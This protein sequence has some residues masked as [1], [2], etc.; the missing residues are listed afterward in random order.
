MGDV[1][2]TQ[3]RDDGAFARLQEFLQAR[4]RHLLFSRAVVD[5][6]AELRSDFGGVKIFW[7]YEGEGELFLNEGFRTKEGDGEPLPSEYAPDAPEGEFLEVLDCLKGSLS[8]ICAPAQAAVYAIL[9]RRK[10]NGAGPAFVGD[11]AG[12]VWK[13]EHAPRPW[14]PDQRV[15]DAISYLFSTYRQRGYS[16]KRKGS[17]EKIMIGDQMITVAD[18]VMKVRGKFECLTVENMGLK[19]RCVPPVMRLRYLKDSS[20]GSNF[21]FDAFRRLP[22]TWYVN[23]PGE[24][25]D[26]VNFVNS[27]IVNIPKETSPSHFHPERPVNGGM[28]QDEM[29][30]V[31]DPKAYRLNTYGREAS[32][33]IYPDLRD[34]FRFERHKLEPGDIVYIPAG[35]GHRGM[36][37][38]VNVITIPG[39]KPHNEYYLDKDLSGAGTDPAV[40]NGSL[41]HLKNYGD[42][43]ALI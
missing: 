36:D 38:F 13:L 15:N 43:G 24:M 7:L 39:F 34:L 1:Y 28:A 40:V 21:D 11:I 14:S 31:L 25:H 42:I 5:G 41:L 35:T 30:L 6:D 10:Q 12:D 4:H 2:S 29:Y 26:G 22:L 8:S 33:I 23:L 9:S 32:L 37:A 17:Y 20:G 16:Q 18:E 3:V 27:H 19:T